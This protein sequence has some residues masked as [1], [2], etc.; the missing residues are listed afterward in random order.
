MLTV[1]E[2]RLCKPAIYKLK[3]LLGGEF[4]YQWGNQKNGGNQKGQE[5]HDFLFE[6][7]GG[8]TLEETMGEP[9]MFLILP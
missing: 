1:L 7:S 3:I 5:G 4:I 8:K 2:V 6:F 9:L